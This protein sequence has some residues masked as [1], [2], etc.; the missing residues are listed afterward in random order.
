MADLNNGVLTD[1]ITN[2]CCTDEILA[3][4]TKGELINLLIRLGDNSAFNLVWTEGNEANPITVER[5]NLDR[6]VFVETVSSWQAKSPNNTKQSH[7][8]RRK[9]NCKRLEIKIA[10]DYRDVLLL[11][12]E[13]MEILTIDDFDQLPNVARELNQ[14]LARA[15][16]TI[17]ELRA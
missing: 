5:T 8:E 17:R 7:T 15:N 13:T 14:K 6:R 9:D 16:N 4:L 1:T 11:L 3:K 10:S 12:N 2:I